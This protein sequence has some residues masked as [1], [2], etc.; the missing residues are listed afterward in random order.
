MDMTVAG[1]DV[2]R[3]CRLTGVDMRWSTTVLARDANLAELDMASPPQRRG[4]TPAVP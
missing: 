2:G 1:A 3:A 4:R